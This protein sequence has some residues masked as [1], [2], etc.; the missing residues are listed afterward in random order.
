MAAIL[1]KQSIDAVIQF[2][3]AAVPSTALLIG[4]DGFDRPSTMVAGATVE[5]V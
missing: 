5:V 4:R 2:I 3:N 1:Y